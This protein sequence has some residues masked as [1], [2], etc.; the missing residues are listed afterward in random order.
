MARRLNATLP[1]L[2]L[3]LAAA[4][5]VADTFVIGRSVPVA[6][7]PTRMQML[8]QNNLKTASPDGSAEFETGVANIVPGFMAFSFAAILT[9]TLLWGAFG[10]EPEKR[11][12]D[13]K[14]ALNFELYAPR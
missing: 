8:A 9:L 14:P 11:E 7:A 3:C 6:R 5:L 1:A 4:W 12:Y 13:T 10:E 2:V